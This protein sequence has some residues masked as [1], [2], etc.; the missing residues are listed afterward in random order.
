[1]LHRSPLDTIL[2]DILQKTKLKRQR[3]LGSGGLGVGSEAAG[4]EVAGLL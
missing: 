4:R 2:F 3:I 1:M